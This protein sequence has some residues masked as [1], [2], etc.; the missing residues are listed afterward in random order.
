MISLQFSSE[1]GNQRKLIRKYETKVSD[2]SSLE[3]LNFG[4]GRSNFYHFIFWTRATP[5]LTTR[6]TA[7]G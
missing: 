1:T 5:N 6:K 3:I 4:F 7:G 2:C